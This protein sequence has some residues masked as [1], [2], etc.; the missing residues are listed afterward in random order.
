VV[1]LADL[2]GKESSAESPLIE[3][4][5]L[6]KLFPIK[7]GV[8]GRT[9]GNVHAVDGVSLSIRKGETLGLVGESGCGKTTFGRAVLR[10]IE[11]TGGRIV[12]EGSDITIMPPTHVRGMRRRLQIVFQDPYGSLDPRMTVEK[13]IGEGF[14]IH[15]PPPSV[16]KN[17]KFA[18]RERVHQLVEQVGLSHDHLLR[19]PHE[20]S[21]GQKQ[22][23]ALARALALEPDFVVLDEPTS[24]LDVSVQA[25]ALNLLKRLQSKFGLT[26]LFISHDLS[27]VAH[28]SDRIAVMYL[29]KV[30]ELAPAMEF[31]NNA[32]HPYTQ[33]LISS[34]PIPDPRMRKQRKGIE[35]EVPSPVNPPK[36]CRFH[37]RCTMATSN[38]GWEGRD[39]A[40]YLEEREGIHGQ[41]HPMSRR[42]RG[43]VPDGF[44]LVVELQPGADPEAV[45][46]W[47]T[48]RIGELRGSSSMF[49]AVATVAV[50]AGKRQLVI[51]CAKAL[52]RSNRLASEF[53]RVLNLQVDY[54]KPNTPMYGII[55]D[56][57]VKESAVSVSVSRAKAQDA[58]EFLKGTAKRLRKTTHPELRHLAWSAEPKIRRISG[59]WGRRNKSQ[60]RGDFQPRGECWITVKFRNGRLAKKRVAELVAKEIESKFN[61]ASSGSN[62]RK[63]IASMKT[64]RGKVLVRLAG[65]EGDWIELRKALR[66]HFEEAKGSEDVLGEAVTSITLKRAR[67]PASAVSVKLES[68]EEPPILDIGGGHLVACVLC[69]GERCEIESQPL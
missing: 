18:E 50:Y 35:G 11:P 66:N 68:V 14:A 13:I 63:T 65:P 64:A 59:A 12:F 17:V 47:L 41:K 10:L 48:R 38:C 15:G 62:L 60:L 22:R 7:K 54:R 4:V 58:L 8:F 26:Y 55:L 21:G 24:A 3:A 69:T 27:V 6:Q 23:I 40:S 67:G 9:V 30:I 57:K 36:G 33:A 61:S 49:D 2:T 1:E 32:K 16:A 28:M 52:I 56:A 45:I 43:L 29:G 42:I 53:L 37:P 19:F 34:I 46:T 31:L 44:N 25:Q 51:G 5:N 20:F 39:L